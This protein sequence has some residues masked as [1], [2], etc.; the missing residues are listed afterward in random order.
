MIVLLDVTEETSTAGLCYGYGKHTELSELARAL[1]IGKSECVV[2]FPNR[3]VRSYMQ[4]SRPYTYSV[5]VEGPAGTEV[6]LPTFGIAW[7]RVEYDGNCSGVMDAKGVYVLAHTGACQFVVTS[8]SPV[9]YVTA[10]LTRA[11]MFRADCPSGQLI[12]M[13]Q[14]W[15][16]FSGSIRELHV[17]SAKCDLGV[18][19]EASTQFEVVCG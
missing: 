8:G 15:D 7:P 17:V 5:A 12:R 4:C 11:G 3:S 9:S 2:S 6:V 10:L 13:M 14:R 16:F 19:C 18:H 1:C